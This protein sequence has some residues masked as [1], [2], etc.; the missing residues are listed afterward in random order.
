MLYSHSPLRL[1]PRTHVHIE[2][3]PKLRVLDTLIPTDTFISVE[4][5]R[6]INKAVRT[7][8]GTSKNTST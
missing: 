1:V 7:R 6:E 2:T 3:R 5:G 8:N 4:E